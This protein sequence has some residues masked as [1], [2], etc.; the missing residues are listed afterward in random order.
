MNVVS[1]D[2]FSADLNEDQ[3]NL[4]DSIELFVTKASKNKDKKTGCHIL[5]MYNDMLKETFQY[6]PEVPLVQVPCSEGTTKTEVDSATQKNKVDSDKGKSTQNKETVGEKR[7]TDIVVPEILNKIAVDKEE[8]KARQQETSDQHDKDMEISNDDT[9]VDETDIL[10]DLI[11]NDDVR[12]SEKDLHEGLILDKKVATDDHLQGRE[13][14][15]IPTDTKKNTTVESQLHSDKEPKHEQDKHRETKV[16]IDNHTN[17]DREETIPATKVGKST[18]DFKELVTNMRSIITETHVFQTIRTQEKDMDINTKA[19][20]PSPKTHTLEKNTQDTQGTN[21]DIESEEVKNI[22]NIDTLKG[23]HVESIDVNDEDQHKINNSSAV[24]HQHNTTYGICFSPVC[25]KM[26]IFIIYMSGPLILQRKENG[27]NNDEMQSGTAGAESATRK[28]IT[29][30]GAIPLEE[31]GKNNSKLIEKSKIKAKRKHHSRKKDF[32]KCHQKRSCNR[33]CHLLY[34]FRHCLSIDEQTK[35][36]SNRTENIKTL[37]NASQNTTRK[38]TRKSHKKKCNQKRS[39]NDYCY[40]VYMLRHCLPADRPN[41]PSKAASDFD[42]RE[43]RADEDHD[44]KDTIDEKINVTNYESMESIPEKLLEKELNYKSAKQSAARDKQNKK[45]ETDI[46]PNVEDFPFERLEKLINIQTDEYGRKIQTLELMII[47]LEN[48][49]LFEKLDKQNHSSTIMRLENMILKLENDLLRMYKNYETL[50]QEGEKCSK[51]HNRFLEIIQQQERKLNSYPE[52]PDKTSESLE[53]ISKHEQMIQDLSRTISN[54]SVILDNLRSKSELLEEQNNILRQMITNQTVFM[55]QI[56]QQVAN[57]TEQNMKYRSELDNIRQIISNINSS[58]PA[59]SASN[60]SDSETFVEKLDSLASEG[61]ISIDNIEINSEKHEIGSYET[62]CNHSCMLSR[63]KEQSSCQYYSVVAENKVI[64]YK[65]LFW[66]K[67]SDDLPA[68]NRT[69]TDDVDLP[70]ISDSEIVKLSEDTNDN[71]SKEKTKVTNQEGISDLI[72][73]KTDSTP[74]HTVHGKEN[75]EHPIPIDVLENHNDTNNEFQDHLKTED[76]QMKPEQNLKADQLHETTQLA[77][78]CSITQIN[79]FECLYKFKCMPYIQN[80]THSFVSD[81]IMARIRYLQESDD[82]FG[83]SDNPSTAKSET[84][85]TVTYETKHDKREENSDTNNEIEQGD[86]RDIPKNQN[87]FNENEENK[88]KQESPTIQH[89]ADSV[90][91]DEEKSK[92]NLKDNMTKQNENK[93]ESQ[94]D[95]ISEPVHSE[96]NEAH[97][98]KE[99]TEQVNS[100]QEKQ[101]EAKETNKEKKV[102]LPSYRKTPIYLNRQ[103]KEPKGEI[104]SIWYFMNHGEKFIQ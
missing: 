83:S 41:D 101:P 43:H 91:D 53:L 39:C 63:V 1:D 13:G 92:E 81:H 11:Q 102:K 52:L 61:K 34:S 93:P 54:Q 46:N 51:Q 47:K 104:V 5:E 97:T 12:V 82:T 64:P 71:E 62:F 67:C 26:D 79:I 58:K 35:Q 90:A 42:N 10:S 30:D 27:Q 19:V 3:Q 65:T 40:L 31:I 36:E 76:K 18:Y 80:K 103:Q 20:K 85:Q 21:E 96:K 25:V 9:D 77:S 44:N 2:I 4:K 74:D 59:E 70:K 98:R 86:P 24:P 66:E 57:L 87:S 22:Q 75:I 23:E 95:K 78:V 84:K 38:H 45:K 28:N 29:E 49:V 15:I 100:K 48:Q 14:E 94:E 73:D 69:V 16:H 68:G 56:V 55:N 37:V 60:I 32:T 50:K 17:L 33:P 72:I 89:Q 7:E 88:L 99:K 6:G 8:P